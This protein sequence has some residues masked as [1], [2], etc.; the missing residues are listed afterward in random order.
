MEIPILKIS[1]YKF[2]KYNTFNSGNLSQPHPRNALNISS[3]HVEYTGSTHNNILSS[4]NII[5]MCG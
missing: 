2:V 3:R 4:D 5:F 1:T